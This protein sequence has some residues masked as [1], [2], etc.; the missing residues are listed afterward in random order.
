[1]KV[2]VCQQERPEGDVAWVPVTTQV[3]VAVLKLAVCQHERFGCPGCVPLTDQR[4]VVELNT[5]V[6]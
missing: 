4:Q 2:A 6:W 5:A 1:L 3:H